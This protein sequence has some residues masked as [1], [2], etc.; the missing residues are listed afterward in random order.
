MIGNSPE[1]PTNLATKAREAANLAESGRK[2]VFEALLGY[3]DP[4]DKPDQYGDTVTKVQG[5]YQARHMKKQF[6]EYIELFVN[7]RIESKP[8]SNYLQ[9][10]LP[11]DVWV[12]SSHET[13]LYSDPSYFRVTE[14]LDPATGE[15][16]KGN[17]KIGLPEFQKALQ[18]RIEKQTALG[19]Q[20]LSD[21]KALLPA[22]PTPS[23]PSAPTG[24]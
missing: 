5:V 13:G 21:A 17:E 24:I 14:N 2:A 22:S 12:H 7:D 10:T 1:V 3:I 16:V 11:G 9:E 8:R 18:E 19:N 4:A 6:G 23:T 15:K 20:Y